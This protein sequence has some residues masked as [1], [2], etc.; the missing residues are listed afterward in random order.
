MAAEWYLETQAGMVFARMEPWEEKLLNEAFAMG[1]DTVAYTWQRAPKDDETGDRP[2]WNYTLDIRNMTQTNDHTC[3]CRR[4]LRL[5]P[6]TNK[7]T[8]P[9]APGTNS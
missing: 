4:M 7:K 3:K 9:F 8:S 1:N 2:I 5:V 6:E